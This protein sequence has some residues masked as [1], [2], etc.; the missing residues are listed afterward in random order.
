MASKKKSADPAVDDAP[1]LGTD[2]A[3]FPAPADAVP[4]VASS[5]V[6]MKL[7]TF[8]PDAA[9]VWFVQAD[10]QFAIRS[11][12]SSK[13]KFYHAVAVWP[14]EVA[15]Q[16][17]DL[18]G[19]PPQ[20]E[21]YKVLRERLIKLYTLNDYQRFEALVSLPL[22]GDQKL[23]H[24]MNRM[25]ALLPDDYKPDFILRG[26]FLRRLPIDVRSH[27]LHE[28]VDNPRALALK[29][30]KLYQSRVSPS[31]VNLLS[32]DFGDSLQVNLVSS[33]AKVP[34]R[35]GTPKLSTSVKNPPSRH[36][37]TQT[38]SP[39]R[40]PT[41]APSSKS[42]NPPGFCWFHKKHGVKATNCRAPCSFS[43]NK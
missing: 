14:Q 24:L 1:V 5:A 40:S 3:L 41:P 42:P 28:K 23:S 36:S 11:I 29:A 35:P 33:R 26:L 2:D 15:S 20:G 8:W 19:A 43:G 10:A 4:V 25:L 31:A 13:E 34:S 18:I 30:D 17:L 21:P 38:R 7:P 16:I 22:P 32:D 6:H 9:E 12:S 39:A 27:L 37:Q